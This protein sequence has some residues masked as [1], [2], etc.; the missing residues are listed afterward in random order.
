M[1]LY[2]IVINIRTATIMANMKLLGYH[3]IRFILPNPFPLTHAK[4]TFILKETA[5]IASEQTMSNAMH[6]TL[7]SHQQE[8]LFR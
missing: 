6:L 8:Y 7:Y 5:D 3:C 4:L 1:H 2:E